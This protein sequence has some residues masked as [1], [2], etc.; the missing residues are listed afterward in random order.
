MSVLGWRLAKAWQGQRADTMQQARA[1]ALAAPYGPAG[2]GATAERAAN[3]T[4]PARTVRAAEGARG[5]VA[6]V[7]PR[8][9]PPTSAVLPAI[10]VEQAMAELDAMIGLGPVKEQIRQLAASVEAAR[11]HEPRPGT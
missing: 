5:Q 9:R 3:G 6:A 11:R 1:A 7:G 10:T 4:D 2:Q 8:D